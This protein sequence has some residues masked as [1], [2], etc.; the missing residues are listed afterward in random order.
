VS[1][2]GPVDQIP[3]EPVAE[4]KK[5]PFYKTWWFWTIIGVAVVGAGTAAGV[6]ATQDGEAAG[7][8]GFSADPG[9]APLDVTLFR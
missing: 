7:Q 8:V 5:A 2:A 1:D 4:V 3:V 9:Y 6:I